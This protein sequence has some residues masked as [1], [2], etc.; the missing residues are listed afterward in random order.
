MVSFCFSPCLLEDAWEAATAE[1]ALWRDG[2][3]TSEA[4]LRCTRN[5]A[6]GAL[7]I[8]VDMEQP[9]EKHMNI[10]EN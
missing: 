2:L 8:T 7:E 4:H 9:M 10:K 3:F 5:G 6:Y 1:A